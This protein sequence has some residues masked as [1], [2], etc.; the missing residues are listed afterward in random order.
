MKKMRPWAAVL[1]NFLNFHEDRS[2]KG[3]LKQVHDVTDRS[4]FISR[5]MTLAVAE[6]EQFLPAVAQSG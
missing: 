5:G 6:R 1:R 3:I 2:A 4:S